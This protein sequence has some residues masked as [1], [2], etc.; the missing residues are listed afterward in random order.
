MKLG[1][2]PATNA[3]APNI[4][5]ASPNQPRKELTIQVNITET[6]KF[7]ELAA[8]ISNML[9]DKRIDNN[10]RQKYLN[11]FKEVAK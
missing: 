10:V 6:D 8:L 5:G 11:R 4:H 3:P 7:K 9:K 1:T 2:N